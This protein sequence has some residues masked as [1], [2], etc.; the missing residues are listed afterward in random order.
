VVL[1]RW[2]IAVRFEQALQAARGLLATS[3]A[4]APLAQEAAGELTR[5]KWCPWHGRWTGCRRR[6]AG[7]RRWARRESAR[8]A[9]SIGRLQRR[10]GE[11]LGHLERNQ[12]ALAPYVARRRRGEPISTAFVECAVNEIVAKRMT[13][14]QQM[15]WSRATVQAFLDVRTA[16]LN[17]T[18][19]DA[20]R[21]R[22]PGFRPANDERARSEAA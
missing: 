22:H 18:L 3:A 15:R 16:V 20:F 10:T 2:H 13:K 19:E 12:D 9:P 21:K 17:G 5:A 11:L 8:D 1:D 14:K 6:L 4:D 7:L